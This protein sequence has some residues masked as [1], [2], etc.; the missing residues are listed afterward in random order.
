M[1]RDIP[2][3]ATPNNPQQMIASN[4]SEPMHA[5]VHDLFKAH[6]EFDSAVSEGSRLECELPEAVRRTNVLDEDI[7]PDDDPRWLASLQ[8]IEH[9]GQAHDDALRRVLTTAPVTGIGAID[10]LLAVR[11]NAGPAGGGFV[12]SAEF[13]ALV[14]SLL[15]FLTGTRR[16]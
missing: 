6:A 8:R 11:S 10:M 13:N 14:D 12:T 1:N 5:L 2:A 7:H 16:Q 4:T 15:S 9:S 3:A